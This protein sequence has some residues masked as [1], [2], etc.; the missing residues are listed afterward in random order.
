MS[1][2]RILVIA[3]HPDDEVSGCGGTMAL[4][5]RAG[6]KVTCVIVCEAESLRYGKKGVGM[7]LHAKRAAAKLSVSDLRLLD[8]PDQKL[9][10]FTS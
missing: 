8:F 9:D 4:H 10:T 2:K 5:I 7:R 3:A 1:G 6:D